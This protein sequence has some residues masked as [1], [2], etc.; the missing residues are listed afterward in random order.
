MDAATAW[1]C[2]KEST[3]AFT[4]PIRFNDPFDTNIAVDYEPNAED[5]RKFYVDHVG[6]AANWSGGVSYSEDQFV[7]EHLKNPTRFHKVLCYARDSFM[8]NTVGVACFTELPND[9]L[10]WASYADKHRGV[11]IGFDATHPDFSEVRFVKYSKTRPV[12]RRLGAK[13]DGKEMMKSDV[14][15]WQQEWRLSA[16]LDQCEVRMLA[17]TPIYVQKVARASFSSITFG[18]RTSPEF[19]TATALSLKKFNLEKCE[20]QEMKLCALTYEVKPK[21]FTI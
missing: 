6:K 4:P 13:L 8:E 20:L 3:L 17:Q 14:W 12:H 16:A 7:A 9:P 15:D 19:K 1:E 21:A 5:L 11:L 18:C 2:L 10:M